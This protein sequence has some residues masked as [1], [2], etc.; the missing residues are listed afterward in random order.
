MVHATKKLKRNYSIEIRDARIDDVENIWEIFNIVIDEGMYLPIASKVVNKADK[1]TWFYD[2]ITSGDFCLVAI[3]K[4]D[5]GMEKFLGQITI[6]SNFEWD[7]IEHVST[8]GILVHPDYRNIGV[9]SALIEEA[10]NEA[11]KRGKLK[12]ILSV[13]NTNQR[14]IALYKKKGFEIIG[15]RRGQFWLNDILID[16][17]M[18]EKWL[19]PIDDAEKILKN[20]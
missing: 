13:F 20:T 17:V 5:S 10:C 4:D 11:L 12:I 7:G 1:R 14:A 18:M 8:L 6:E 16:E 9:G 15:T 2:L 3:M 19:V